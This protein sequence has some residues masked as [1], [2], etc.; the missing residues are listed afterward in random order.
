MTTTR[1]FI[2]QKKARTVHCAFRFKLTEKLITLEP[3][4]S[5]FPRTIKHQ[6]N[7][8]VIMHTQAGHPCFICYIINSTEPDEIVIQRI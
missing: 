6:Y 5:E 1:T 3:S 2:T 7:V 8:H 4:D